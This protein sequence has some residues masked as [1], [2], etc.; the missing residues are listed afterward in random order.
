MERC[1][2]NVRRVI[3][4]HYLAEDMVVRRASAWVLS[5]LRNGARPWTRKEFVRPTHGTLH[6]A[7][8]AC[9]TVAGVWTCHRNI[10]HVLIMLKVLA[11]LS[12]TFVAAC[13]YVE[14]IGHMIRGG[15]IH[16]CYYVFLS[17]ILCTV[18]LHLTKSKQC[19]QWAANPRAST[20][21]VTVPSTR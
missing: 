10:F 19:S 14:F 1:K 7:C 17:C 18:K 6:K 8:L 4:C 12:H 11:N 13:W 9:S 20:P 3:T 2:R 21:P 16:L 15:N 5:G